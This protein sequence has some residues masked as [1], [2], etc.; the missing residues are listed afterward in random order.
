MKLFIVALLATF[1]L[2]AFAT[3]VDCTIRAIQENG[4]YSTVDKLGLGVQEGRYLSG[5]GRPIS[6]VDNLYINAKLGSSDSLTI[7][8]L[9]ESAHTYIGKPI[10]ET[11]G[12]SKLLRLTS[13][14]DGISIECMRNEENDSNET[15]EINETNEKSETGLK[16]FFKRK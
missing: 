12:N 2:T 8:L 6:G 13:F 11:E 9:S 4:N 10:A 5:F 7:T 14:K 16:K 1:S 3:T 15:N